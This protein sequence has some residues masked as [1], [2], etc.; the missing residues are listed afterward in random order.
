MIAWISKL[1]ATIETSY[2]IYVGKE[3]LGY[4]DKWFFYFGKEVTYITDF[5]VLHT[6]FEGG[7]L[8]THMIQIWILQLLKYEFTIVHRPAQILAKAD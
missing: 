2:Y 1:W 8:P 6:L 3:I 7:N 4:G 5:S